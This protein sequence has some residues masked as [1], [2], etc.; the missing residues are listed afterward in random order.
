M[1]DI[2]FIHAP[3]RFLPYLSRTRQNM[4]FSATMSKQMENLSKTYLTNRQKVQISPPNVTVDEVEKGLQCVQKAQK[5]FQLIKILE[6]HKSTA[7]L[8]FRTPNMAQKD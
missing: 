5:K 3:R 7:T 1:L 4:L 6:N 2:G 8:I